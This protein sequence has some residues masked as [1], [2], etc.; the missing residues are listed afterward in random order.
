MSFETQGS[1]QGHGSGSGSGTASPR[2]GRTMLF[3]WIGVAFVVVLALVAGVLTWV[4][5]STA[6]A[7]NAPEKAVDA[8]LSAV[9]EGRAEDA[10]ALAGGVPNGALDALVTDEA[11]S[12]AGDHVTGYTLGRAA[13]D[14]DG[15]TVVAQIE[16][17]DRRYEQTFHLG[18][19][20]KE[21]L[22]VDTWALDPQ[23]LGYLTVAFDGPA[24]ASVV[25]NGQTVDASPDEIVSRP[26]IALPGSYVVGS[27]SGDDEVAI[28]EDSVTVTSLSAAGDGGVADA[29]LTASLTDAGVA[30]GQ[31]AVDAY[32]DACVAQPVMAP[33]G[34]DFY[35]EPEAGETVTNLVWSIATRPTFTIGGWTPDGWEVLPATGGTIYADGDFTNAEGYGTVRY[36]L[37]NYVYSGVLNLVDGVMTFTYTGSNSPA[38]SGA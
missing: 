25:V 22:V 28:G 10:V 36:T 29:T 27:E 9:V 14:D 20:G 33:V 13:I 7:R 35:A 34:C 8:Y 12:A 30:G 18:R 17:G 31:A 21:V 16:Q 11:Y 15:A 24:G 1:G 23:E 19:V 3:V 37:S 38:G 32:L 4:A 6:T 5:V 2:G 26:L